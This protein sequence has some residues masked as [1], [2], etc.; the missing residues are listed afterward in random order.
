MTYKPNFEV[1]K[2]EEAVSVLIIFSLC[3]HLAVAF[4]A[5]WQWG[6][7]CASLLDVVRFLYYYFCETC[8]ADH[9]VVFIAVSSG[10]TTL[11]GFKKTI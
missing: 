4:L 1:V 9:N 6:G 2:P 5:D 7:L 11:F 3:V 10:R 8:K